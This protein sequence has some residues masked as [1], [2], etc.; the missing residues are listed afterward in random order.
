MLG[1][2]IALGDAEQAGQPRF[3]G[4]Q[5]VAALVE[6]MLLDPVADRQQLALAAHQEGEIHLEGEF[7]GALAQ[8]DQ[9]LAQRGH[10]L[11]VDMRILEMRLAG[12]FQACRPLGQDLAARRLRLGVDRRC[13]L[14]DFR[15]QYG[16][17]DG[18]DRRHLGLR[19]DRLDGA[20]HAIDAVG[21]TL[22]QRPELPA[23]IRQF[24]EAVLQHG[25]A[26][27][28]AFEIAL[29]MHGGRLGPFG[30]SRGDG[31]EVAGEIAAVDGRHVKRKERLQPFGVVP[32]EEMAAVALH[33]L[34]GG[35]GR[36]DAAD[37]F[38]QADPAE[39][40]G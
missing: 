36:F 5:I 9:P 19:L 6:L 39:I 4:Q 40:A 23:V 31:H 17:I 29:Q 8:L 35:H 37:C 25:D 32:V 3:G 13:E 12:G 20:A 21:E 22:A 38:R 14:A 2:Q 1:R 34:D 24:V 26:V 10:V 30:A 27:E 16:K 33:R 7:S 28:D 11:V 18:A 15:R